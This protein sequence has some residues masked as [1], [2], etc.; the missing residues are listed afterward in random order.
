MLGKNYTP[1]KTT[2]GPGFTSV[3]SQKDQQTTQT[4]TP[5]AN[6]TTTTTSTA[7]SSNGIISQYGQIAFNSVLIFIIG[8]LFIIIVRNMMRFFYD[9]FNSGRI[10]YLKVILPRGQ[11]KLDREQ[12]KELAKDMKE[13]I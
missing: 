5:S 4:G 10:I 6:T 13:K 1:P 12:E 8:I 9:V 11:S 3:G 7:T 2:T